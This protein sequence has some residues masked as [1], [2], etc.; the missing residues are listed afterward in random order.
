MAHVS[1][2]INV[3]VAGLDPLV[4]AAS[5]AAQAP[6][7]TVQVRRL[8]FPPVPPRGRGDTPVQL[9]TPIPLCP[10]PDVELSGSLKVSPP[11]SGLGLIVRCIVRPFPS[12]HL[13]LR[14]RVFLQMTLP[15]YFNW[16]AFITAGDVVAAEE[17]SFLVK[18]SLAASN[19]FPSNLLPSSGLPL[20]TL[21][22]RSSL[23]GSPFSD[24]LQSEV[25]IYCDVF[26]RLF[27]RTACMRLLAPSSVAMVRKN[28]VL[29]RLTCTNHAVYLL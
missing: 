28:D 1:Q 24:L 3:G 10:Y 21:K 2:L 23:G 8:A 18:L 4:D 22:G 16:S 5:E 14:P 26:A 11:A 9:G 17:A 25:H 19:T 29:V 15:P 7:R 12:I 13:D 27:F 6:L 20:R